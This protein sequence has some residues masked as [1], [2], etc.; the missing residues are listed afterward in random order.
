MNN[1]IL[2]PRSSNCNMSWISWVDIVILPHRLL[3][4]HRNRDTCPILPDSGVDHDIQTDRLV[5]LNGHFM[6]QIPRKTHAW[7]QQRD[8]I[9]PRWK[10]YPIGTICAK[11]GEEN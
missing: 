3:G 10:R 2:Q 5:A 1:G 9:F 6:G 11:F 4:R 8:H 7:P